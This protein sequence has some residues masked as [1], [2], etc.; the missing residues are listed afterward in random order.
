MP[1]LVDVG[2]MSLIAVGTCLGVIYTFVLLFGLFNGRAL[3]FLLEALRVIGRNIAVHG[4]PYLLPGCV[5][6]S[7]VLIQ[8]SHRLG[9]AGR[10]WELVVLSGALGAVVTGLMTFLAFL[11][12]SQVETESIRILIIL[13][14][15]G[16]LAGG[17]SGWLLCRRQCRQASRV[18]RDQVRVAQEEGEI[19]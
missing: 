13:A 16:M 11:L 1:F 18:F 7:L 10:V 5:L 2:V 8:L 12:T 17:V 14:S 4:S 19:S 6:H 9:Y 15:L 3:M